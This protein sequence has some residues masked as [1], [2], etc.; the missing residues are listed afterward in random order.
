MVSVGLCLGP[1]VI[2]W[3][4]RA[5]QT[6][7]VGVQAGFAPVKPVAPPVVAPRRVPILP[8]ALAGALAYRPRWIAQRERFFLGPFQGVLQSS[9]ALIQLAGISS[10][11]RCA[12]RSGSWRLTGLAVAKGILCWDSGSHRG[13]T[14]PFWALLLSRRAARVQM[15]VWAGAKPCPGGSVPITSVP[16]LSPAVPLVQ[17]A[18]QNPWLEVSQ[19]CFTCES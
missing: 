1:G 8:V 17:L 13:W 15:L 14:V 7:H 5:L 3:E 10:A 18:S 6:C 19:G 4:T 16:R 11:A 9:S 2:F 12:A